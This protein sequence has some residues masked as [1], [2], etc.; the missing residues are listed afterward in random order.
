MIELDFPVYDADNHLYETRDALTR[1]LDRR[2]RRELRYVEINGRTKIAICGQISDYIP[3]PT[4]EV[5]ARPGAYHRH[6]GSGKTRREVGRADG[7]IRCPDEFRDPDGRLG[8][9]DEQGVHAV[10]LF[11]TLVSVLE[12]R[13][14]HDAELLN[15]ALHAFNCWLDE[16]WSFA[17]KD[18]LFPVPMLSL[19][20]VDLAV[21]ELEWC[22]ERGARIVGLRPAPVPSYRGSRSPGL[23]EFDPFWARVAEVGI[24]VGFHSSDSGYDRYA[25][26]WEGGTEF[27]PF[28][29]T[30]LRMALSANPIHDTLAA[31]I[32]HGLFERHPTLR[33]A[34]I[35]NGSGWVPALL[36][37]L[38]AVVRD[39]DPR[40]TFRRNIW[41]APAHGENPRRLADEIGV[42]HVLFG[43]DFPHPEGLEKPLSYADELG[44]FDAGEIRKVMGANLEGLLQPRSV[45]AAAHQ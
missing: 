9:M 6:Q 40:E 8:L 43:S 41:V 42:D 35:E 37:R 16:E 15:A 33:I 23:P 32:C 27:K 2:Y 45:S 21:R 14:K 31:L 17:Y 24:P 26:D 28:E 11:G 30:P 34:S 1:H 20:D 29:A 22:L 4:F 3:N 19:M 12:E 39:S 44:D 7:P 10:L 38:S 5:V 36:S 18:R 13:M 25:A